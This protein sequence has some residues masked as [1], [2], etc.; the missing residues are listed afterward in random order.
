MDKI[1]TFFITI[2]DKLKIPDSDIQPMNIIKKIAMTLI[3]LILIKISIKAI[4]KIVDKFFEG[5]QKMK[6]KIDD[7]KSTTFSSIIK[8]IVR[9]GIYFIGG[10]MILD[11]YEVD[12]SPILATAGI[13]GLA[14]GFGAQNFVR[15]II[16]GFFILLENQYSVGD[17]IKI[18]SSEGI[19]E[20][21][22]IRSTKIRSFNG[23]LHIV[24]NGKVEIVT[25]K[26]R[27][28]SRAWV[29][30]SIAYEE[31]I[32]NAVE[33]LKKVCDKVAKENVNIIEGPTV[34]G[35]TNLGDSDVVISVV[36]KTKPM[37]QWSVER[38]LRRLI[39]YEFDKKGI[40]IPYPKRVLINENN[41]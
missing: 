14:I 33:S 19:V 15:D 6:Y 35:V 28:L 21:M 41:D 38:D 26:S 25:N 18:N 12:I 7:R 32:D 2:A 10:V 13:G 34:L 23:D 30:V 3:L 8:S 22:T 40:E 39:K 27:G 24:P 11:I 5:Q 31:D 16:T 29:D 36:A 17:Y 1:K 9:Y 4:N 20:E 37:E